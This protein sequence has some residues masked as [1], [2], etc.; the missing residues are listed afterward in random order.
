[1][2]TA[3][4]V[5]I[6]KPHII[7]MKWSQHLL[8]HQM[9]CSSLPCSQSGTARKGWDGNVWPEAAPQPRE[10][11]LSVRHQCL[12]LTR[13]SL[14]SNT[15]PLGLSVPQA[16]QQP[17]V[18]SGRARWDSETGPSFTLA[19]QQAQCESQAPH[20][21]QDPHKPQ[22]FPLKWKCPNPLQEAWPMCKKGYELC[23]S[24][25]NTLLH[26][27]L[28]EWKTSWKHVSHADVK[29]F[30]CEQMSSLSITQQ[31]HSGMTQLM[32]KHEKPTGS[33]TI[34]LFLSDIVTSAR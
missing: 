24:I 25:C 18:L 26:Q 7:A 14:S 32:H 13:G 22:R 5:R 3:V 1:M 33:K 6:C 17:P 29:V 16:P 30:L 19:S 27:K 12:L 8:Q 20:T 10:V 34:V 9:H 23:F 11:N 2:L 28:K 15:S 31:T 21:R 4:S